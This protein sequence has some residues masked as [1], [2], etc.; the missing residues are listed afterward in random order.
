MTIQT[1]QMKNFIE[2]VDKAVSWWGNFLRSDQ[3]EADVSTEDYIDAARA[4]EGDEKSKMLA[5]FMRMMHEKSDRQFYEAD[6]AK[7]EETLKYLIIGRVRQ[8]LLSQ[9]EFSKTQGYQNN[10]REQDII[11]L[12][13][14]LEQADLDSLT[15]LLEKYPEGFQGC[16]ASVV[17]NREDRAVESF[18]MELTTDH[19]LQGFVLAAAR[20]AFG[21]LEGEYVPLPRKTYMHISSTGDITVREPS[22]NWKP[23][24]LSSREEEKIAT[25]LKKSFD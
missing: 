18:T 17:V 10:I 15:A 13:K 5:N 14:V 16:E 23:E 12:E 4:K 3:S 11:N 19:A 9:E 1:F 8:K 2:A 7:F 20:E 22:N 24:M 21:E 6:I 25:D